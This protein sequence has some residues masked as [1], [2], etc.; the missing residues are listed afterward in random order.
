MTKETPIEFLHLAKKLHEAFDGKL[1]QAAS[2][3]LTDG[4]CGL[5]KKSIQR[6]N[7]I[8]L[9]IQ[10]CFHPIGPRVQFG[11]RFRPKESSRRLCKTVPELAL[12]SERHSLKTP[13]G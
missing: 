9:D 7:L 1:P 12:E 8:A 3:T 4:R 10:E 11:E 2:G 6:R 13:G 5:S